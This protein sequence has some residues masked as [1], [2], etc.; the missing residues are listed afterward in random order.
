MTI[1]GLA[2]LVL[3]EPVL[4]GAM[5]DAKVGR[6]H[7]R[8][9]RP[10]S[11]AAVR[12]ARAWS[13][14]GARCSWWPPPCARPR[15]S[16]RSSQDLLDPESVA[17][18]PA[19]ETLPHERLSPR[20][21]TVGRR[22]AVLRRIEHP[23]TDG[24]QRPAPGGRRADPLGAAAAGEG[25]G[26]PRAGRAGAGPG[27]RPRGRRTTA[28]GCGVLPRRPGR[29]A[30]R[31]RR[32]RRHRRRL[33]ADRG[34]PAARGVLRRRGRR[35]PQLRRGRPAHDSDKVERA[36]GAAVPRAAAD[37]RRTAPRGR[38]RPGAPR[39]CA[40]SPTSSPR[41]WP[42][43]GWSRS[44]RCWSTRWRC[45][46]TCCPPDTHVLRARP[47]AGPHPRRT[48][49]S[50][51]ARSSSARAGPRRRRAGRR[52]STSAPR[53]CAASARCAP[54][55]LDRGQAGGGSAR[56]AWTWRGAVDTREVGG[57]AATGVP[58][59]HR[60][61]RRRHPR[62]PRR[63]TPG[64][65]DPP[66]PRA[67]AAHGRGA[68]RA[69]HRRAAGRR[70]WSRDARRRS[71][72]GHP[73][74]PRRRAAS[75]TAWSST[76]RGWSSSPAR[77]SPAR[78][79]PRATCA[80]CRPGA[81]SRSTRSSSRPAT[82]SSTSSTASA[83]SWRCGSARC[84]ARSREYLVL[85]YGA[86]QARPPARPALRAGRRARPG[87]PLRRRRAA[88]PRPA[89]RRRLGQAQGPCPQG[90]AP[91]RGRADQALRRPAGHQGPRVRA[92]HPVADRARGRLPVPRDPRPA[93]HGRGGQGRHASRR[94]R[95]TGWSAA[96]SAT[97]RPRSPCGP[98]SRRCRTAS[99]SPSWCRRRC[100]SPSTTPP[101]P[102]G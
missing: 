66:G 102:S 57:P 64:G 49:W 67:R 40:R 91:D 31:V 33:P 29:E 17:F 82:S 11:A 14:P 73:G 27:G 5:D 25:A 92:G 41:A 85:E 83:G 9:D 50:P 93:E 8:P 59:R 80:R 60:A 10:R 52:R 15:T 87:H 13:T 89:R 18:Y 78:R 7:A 24:R 32:A 86:V 37:R 61:G 84:T 71:L 76:T 95:W 43:R 100:S 48:T 38:A 96:T 42:S 72:P 39:S 35:D 65:H 12:G 54:Q 62:P 97:A 77:T 22:L 3:R 55:V 88:Q 26:R 44:P 1:A 19:W 21:D 70:R 81:R 34:A 69:R 30:R 68:G 2:D 90:G 75:S 51:P 46:S 16:P 56:S 63:R 79:P 36:L 98:R 6:E 28:R 94:T 47:R 4:A 74:L 45:S 99:R 23:G 101:S 58:R 53:R 20:S